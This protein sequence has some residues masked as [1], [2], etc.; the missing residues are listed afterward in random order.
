[1]VRHIQEGTVCR[2]KRSDAVTGGTRAR[3][4]ESRTTLWRRII[5]C[6]SLVRP[7]PRGQIGILKGRRAGCRRLRCHDLP[8]LLPPVEAVAGDAQRGALAVVVGKNSP[9]F[10]H[11][12]TGLRHIAA[13]SYK[14]GQDESRL[15]GTSL[16]LR[17][18]L[19]NTL[20]GSGGYC[21]FTRLRTDSL[22]PEAERHAA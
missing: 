1:M 3:Q 13:A 7:K 10:I 18:E 15:V 4:S 12:V 19:Q 2:Q 16:D 5:A 22:N 20:A 17:M 14:L 9:L 8:L 6:R 11:A 21:K